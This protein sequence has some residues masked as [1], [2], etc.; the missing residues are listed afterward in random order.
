MF[1]MYRLDRNG[2][3]VP[4]DIREL[5]D[6]NNPKA[7]PETAA[8]IR[9]TVTSPVTERPLE[10]DHKEFSPGNAYIERIRNPELVERYELEQIRRKRPFQ[11][12]IPYYYYI[13]L[14]GEKG[15]LVETMMV[16]YD[17]GGLKSIEPWS[18][19]KK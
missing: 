7:Y 16:L 15:I 6:E 11:R 14:Y 19:P 12:G 4:R 5:I 3:A 2:L 10:Y 9:A 8:Y 18:P 13:R 17:Q 1:R